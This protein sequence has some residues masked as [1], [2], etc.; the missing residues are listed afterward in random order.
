MVAEAF[1]SEHSPG[2][3]AA[4]LVF[5]SERSPEPGLARS[6]V[7]TA[8]VRSEHSPGP[9]LAWSVAATATFSFGPGLAGLVVAT[10]AFYSKY[11][12]A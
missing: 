10:M 12:P 4:M 6:E 11:S 2:P 3:E 7:V 5:R 9:G 8:V 1:C